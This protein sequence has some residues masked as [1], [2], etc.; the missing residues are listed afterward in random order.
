MDGIENLGGSRSRIWETMRS[1]D[2]AES[3]RVAERVE[4][5][6]G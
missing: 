5:R 3:D 4:T 1:S 2:G 6:C